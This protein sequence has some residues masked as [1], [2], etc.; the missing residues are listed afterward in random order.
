MT[1]TT[2]NATSARRHSLPTTIGGFENLLIQMIEK[3][4]AADFDMFLLP[5]VTACAQCWMMT[6]RVHRDLMK[7]DSLTAMVEGSKRQWSEEVHPL[8]PY[9]LKLQAE[10]R[11][12]FE[13]LGLNYR[14]TPSKIKEDAKRGVDDTDPMVEFYK[15]SNR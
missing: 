15:N 10:L 11:L 13:A 5:Q 4:T 12:Q 3:R 2:K 9:Y 7:M 1:K 6:N 14:A 8:L